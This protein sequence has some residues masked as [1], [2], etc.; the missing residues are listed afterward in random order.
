MFGEPVSTI[1]WDVPGYQVDMRNIKRCG[2][3]DVEGGEDSG[4]NQVGVTS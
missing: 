1:L 3:T 4:I 2:G